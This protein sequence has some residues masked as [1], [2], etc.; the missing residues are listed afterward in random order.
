MK[1]FSVTIGLNLYHFFISQNKFLNAA[2][3]DICPIMKSTND[4]DLNAQYMHLL[5][6]KMCRMYRSSVDYHPAQGWDSSLSFDLMLEPL[7]LCIKSR[8]SDSPKFNNC[9][10][11]NR[12]YDVDNNGGFHLVPGKSSH[13]T[14]RIP[15]GHLCKFRETAGVQAASCFLLLKLTSIGISAG[16]GEIFVPIKSFNNDACVIIESLK[17]FQPNTLQLAHFDKAVSVLKQYC[18]K[19]P[20]NLAPSDKLSVC[21]M[22]LFNEIYNNSQLKFCTDCDTLCSVNKDLILIFEHVIK[23]YISMTDKPTTKLVNTFGRDFI[24]QFLTHCIITPTHVALKSNQN[25]IFP[26]NII[27]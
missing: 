16:K 12:R 25:F 13:S 9:P 18:R 22:K 21:G 2:M 11:V 14:V 4:E 3:P 17:K 1:L 24:N 6:C 8:F 26:I 20:N 10:L 23:L 7:Q 5:A 15:G 19:N 27:E